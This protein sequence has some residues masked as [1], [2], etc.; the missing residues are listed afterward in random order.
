[1]T[2]RLETPESFTVCARVA[3]FTAWWNFTPVQQC[4][5]GR[6][7][8]RSVQWSQVELS[9]MALRGGGGVGMTP[10]LKGGDQTAFSCFQALNNGS[11]HGHGKW[12]Q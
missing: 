6:Q 8:F 9:L 3:D 4:T 10:G 11:A 2:G 12:V 5:T 7:T 1:M